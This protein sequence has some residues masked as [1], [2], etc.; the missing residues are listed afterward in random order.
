[1][2]KYLGFWCVSLM[3]SDNLRVLLLVLSTTISSSYTHMGTVDRQ[4]E[5]RWQFR[6][7]TVAIAE[8]QLPLPIIQTRSSSSCAGLLLPPRV[9]VVVVVVVLWDMEG[10]EVD[11]EVIVVNVLLGSMWVLLLGMLSE[12]TV[13]TKRARQQQRKKMAGTNTEKTPKQLQCLD[14]I[15]VSCTA[16]CR[17]NGTRCVHAHRQTDRQTDSSFACP[18]CPSV[19]VCAIAE[20]SSSPAFVLDRLLLAGRKRFG[21]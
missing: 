12:V 15:M 5:R 10:E 3:S 11:E 18:L 21:F 8:P 16:M 17:S 9:V 2:G 19:C 6:P 20:M 7:I 4:K 1:M 13:E 14:L